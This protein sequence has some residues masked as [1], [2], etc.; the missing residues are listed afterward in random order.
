MGQEGEKDPKH[1]R[2]MIAEGCEVVMSGYPRKQQYLL[3][4]AMRQKLPPS[5]T[6]DRR[7]TPRRSPHL[8][9]LEPPPRPHHLDC[10][11]LSQP[12]CTISSAVARRRAPSRRTLKRP[13]AAPLR[14]NCPM[15]RP[16]HTQ[17]SP[18]ATACGPT[19]PF[20][21]PGAAPHHLIAA[22]PNPTGPDQHSI[23]TRRR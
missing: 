15:P 8:G 21:A 9:H 7:S 18:H 16:L 12:P 4:R 5:T 10:P 17:L 14:W 3:L 1:G 19:T 2:V 20:S 6:I 11:P 23:T 13:R 22:A